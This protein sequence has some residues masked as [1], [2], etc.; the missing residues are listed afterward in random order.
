M[1][2][3]MLLNRNFL[4]LNP[5]IVGEEDCAPRHSYGPAVRE[6]TLIHFVKKGEGILQKNG[7]EYPIHAGEAF[8][9]LPKEVTVYTASEGDPWSYTWVGFDGALSQRFAELEPVFS[10]QKNWA[11]EMIKVY[12]YDGTREYKLVSLLFEMF[13]EFF[14]PKKPSN[15]YVRRVNDYIQ[16]MYMQQIR[17]EQIAKMMNLDRRY[18]SRIFKEK[19]GKSIQEYLIFVR[20]EAAKKLLENGVTVAEAAQLCGYEDVCNFSKMF[21]RLFGVSPRKWG[22]V[23]K[24]R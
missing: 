16:S 12:D 20:M 4:D 8:I 10:Y 17:V 1:R 18:L 23:A 5:L 19:M 21:K 2:D 3:L 24:D 15:H 9:I 14:T 22:A 7:K 11:D 6:Y 13:A